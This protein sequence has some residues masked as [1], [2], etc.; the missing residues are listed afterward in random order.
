MVI[1]EAEEV[2][3]IAHALGV[4]PASELLQ[5]RA[6][7]VLDAVAHHEAYDPQVEVV[8]VPQPGSHQRGEGRRQHGGDEGQSG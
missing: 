8:R 2:V 3:A 4:V 5:E 6:R 7:Q 1:R